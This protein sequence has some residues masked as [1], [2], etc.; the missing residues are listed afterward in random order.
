VTGATGYTQE[1]SLCW[2][3]GGECRHGRPGELGD[4]GTLSAAPTYDG[5]NCKARVKILA[6]ELAP[7]LH[8]LGC[9]SLN[10]ICH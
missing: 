3:S 5:M 1:I 7:Y 6:Q 8:T 10:G 4:V 2:C 9:V